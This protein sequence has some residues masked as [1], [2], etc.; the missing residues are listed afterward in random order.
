MVYPANSDSV[1]EA[2]NKLYTN[3]GITI[4]ILKQKLR[5]YIRSKA[6]IRGLPSCIFR[7]SKTG[8]KPF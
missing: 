1:A 3:L 6:L 5:F 2:R 4:L 8:L 7:A